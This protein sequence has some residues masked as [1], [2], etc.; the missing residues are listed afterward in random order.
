MSNIDYKSKYLKYKNKYDNLNRTNIQSG[1][2]ERGTG[3]AGRERGTPAANS[4]FEMLQSARA[5]AQRE[6][7][8]FSGVHAGNTGR[9]TRRQHDKSLR[10]QEQDLGHQERDELGLLED[11]RGQDFEETRVRRTG[12]GP[13]KKRTQ[14]SDDSESPESQSSEADIESI[15]A[16]LEARKQ[17]L[18]ALTGKV[19]RSAGRKA[20]LDPPSGGV[21]SA[22]KAHLREISALKSTITQPLDVGKDSGLPESFLAASLPQGDNDLMTHIFDMNGKIDKLTEITIAIARNAGLEIDEDEMY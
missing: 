15:T 3:G 21:S 16:D 9:R 2:A 7:A 18:V 1:G 20:A 22:F 19:D 12:T 5:A 14:K 13:H 8:K 17:D 4:V 11:P 10:Q 6:D